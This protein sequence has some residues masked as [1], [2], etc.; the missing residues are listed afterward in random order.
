MKNITENPVSVLPVLDALYIA[1]KTNN[2]QET[3]GAKT[4]RAKTLG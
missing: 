4:I 3:F 1:D 2:W